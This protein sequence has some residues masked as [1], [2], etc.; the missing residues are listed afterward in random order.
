[1]NHL[2][3]QVILSETN[4]WLINTT[5]THTDRNETTDGSKLISKHNGIKFCVDL[6][7][8][9]QQAQ[10]QNTLKFV[11][12]SLFLSHVGI[13]RLQ[14]HRQ[15][16]PS[17][18]VQIWPQSNHSQVHRAETA[19]L[20]LHHNGEWILLW[21]MLEPQSLIKLIYLHLRPFQGLANGKKW[22]FSF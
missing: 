12:R 3:F 11:T 19:L 6:I 15:D 8:F 5:A 4:L 16:H 9:F 10:L 17:H 22:W 2:W 1:M 20:P 13:C 18:L 14:P 21:V 7:D